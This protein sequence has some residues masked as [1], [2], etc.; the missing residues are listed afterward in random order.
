MHGLRTLASESGAVQGRTIGFGIGAATVLAP[1]CAAAAAG[2]T[3]SVVVVAA[4]LALALV[5]TGAALFGTD[6]IS[7]R[8]L[9]LIC[10]FLR[11]PPG[12]YLAPLRHAD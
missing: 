4:E 9:I 5:L 11:R 7:T 2:P 3:L 6:R 1:V 10:L 12:T 8:A